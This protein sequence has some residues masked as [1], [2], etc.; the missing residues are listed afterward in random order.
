M[1]QQFRKKPKRGK[2]KDEGKLFAEKARTGKLN[3]EQE[4]KKGKNA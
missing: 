4:Y 3:L 2:S 1:K